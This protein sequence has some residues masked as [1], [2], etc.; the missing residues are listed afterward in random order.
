MVL[1]LGPRACQTRGRI[2]TAAALVAG[3]AALLG[4][5]AVARAQLADP[6]RFGPPPSD[7]PRSTGREV[8]PSLARPVATAV[9]VTAC[10]FTEPVCVH[11]AP[12]VDSGAVLGVL[13]HAEH[14]FR[15]Y[16]ALGLPAPHPPYDVY[17]LPSQPAPATVADLVPTSDGWDRASAFTVMPPPVA[18]GGCTASFAVAQ[19]VAH[20]MALGLDAGAEN[21]ALSMASSYLASLVADCAAAELPAID[22]FQAHPERSFAAG[23]PDRPDGALLFP[24]FLDDTLGVG[25]P[26]RVMVGLLALGAQRTPPGSWEWHNEPD[27]F[28][29]MRSSMRFR[30]SS[31]ENLLLDFAVARA[32]VGSRSDGAHLADVE[33]FGDAGR[34][35][36]EWSVPFASLPRRL[37]PLAPIDPTG[38]T[39]VWLD[40]TGAPPGAELTLVADWERPALFRWSVVKVDTNGAAVGRLDVAGVF[41]AN[42]AE[43]TVMGLDGLAGVMVVGVNIGSDDRSH[44]FDP[45]EQPLMPHGYTVTLVK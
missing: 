36:F 23:D 27:I 4:G 21:G 11:A 15:A 42:H 35:R 29:V 16:R 44:P 12:R 32:F 6:G 9:P 45:D 1:G 41:G 25:G 13:G 30:G 17:L 33:R 7:E 14:A 2:V 43:K 31:L 8:V 38:M 37:A 10:S 18:D 40:L 19:G 22:D 34:V 20:A 28:D 39:Y 26:G 24:W 5:D 3:V